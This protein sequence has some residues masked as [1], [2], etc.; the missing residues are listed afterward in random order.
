[1]ERGAGRVMTTITSHE[2]NFL[3]F[4]YLHESGVY[5][6]CIARRNFFIRR[7]LLMRVAATGDILNFALFS[8]FADGWD[9][10]LD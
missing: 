3:I 7:A 2:L 9:V 6:I 8:S 10:L 1:M 4:R 5:V